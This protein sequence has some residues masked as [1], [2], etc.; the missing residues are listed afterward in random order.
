MWVK[1]E[2][3]GHESDQPMGKWVGSVFEPKY[4]V[5]FLPG[6]LFHTR[7][8]PIL[9]NLAFSSSVVCAYAQKIKK[10]IET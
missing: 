8:W 7:K 2:T 9:A 6:G 4:N 10:K 3:F 1:G 5:Y